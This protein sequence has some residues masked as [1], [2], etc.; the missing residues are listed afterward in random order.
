MVNAIKKVIDNVKNLKKLR[1]D[2][3]VVNLG[4]EPYDIFKK[5]IKI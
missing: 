3:G 5:R 4:K 2:T 1:E